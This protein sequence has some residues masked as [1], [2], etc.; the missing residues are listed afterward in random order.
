MT[1]PTP[2]LQSLRGSVLSERRLKVLL[3][4]LIAGLLLGIF[5]LGY[6]VVR[7]VFDQMLP[8][9]RD[10]LVWKTVHGAKEIAA[11]AELGI[12]A[13][14]A[15]AIRPLIQDM[16]KDADTLAVV[17]TDERGTP[18]VVAGQLPETTAVFFHGRPGALRKTDAYL[19][20]WAPAVIE[21]S[22][23]GRVAVITATRSLKAGEQLARRMILI[24]GVGSIAALLVGLGFIAFYI[25]PLV[26]LNREAFVQL[27]QTTSDA[28][29]LSEE[30]VE[31]AA[32]LEVRVRERTAE[33]SAANQ[34]LATN[35]E[36]LKEAQRKLVDISRQA[37]MAEIATGLLHN[38]GNVLN[39]VNVSASLVADRLNRS[40]ISGL[41]KAV[42][43][44]QEQ[45][46]KV[47]EFLATDPRGR[48]LPEFLGLL[49][50]H[51][52]SEVADN[53]TEMA[54]LTKHVDHIKTI[55][56]MQQAHARAGGVKEVLSLQ[57]L[58]EDA[59]KLHE[60]S[61][62]RHD[63]D[64]V[65]DLEDLPLLS[66]DRHKTLQILLNLL[67]NAKHALLHVPP[68]RRSLTIRVH[69]NGDERVHV[70]VA[71]T[72]TGIAPE[73]LTRIFSH[74]FTTKKDGHGFGLHSS[75]LAAQE[76][77]GS[78]TVHS[79]G[80]GKGATFTLSL[81]MERISEHGTTSDRHPAIKA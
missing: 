7:Q 21:G 30:K 34:A 22:A 79:D 44:L 25:G 23:V 9:L 61:L 2:T 20:A 41:K 28:V 37:G 3:V 54:S 64:L 24:A 47:S 31:L 53:R 51:L 81:P 12:A 11:S 15:S 43:L 17:V 59:L 36:K 78:L 71:D 68:G 10:D 69:A 58:V 40:K 35:L 55:V 38:V 66:I 13:H 49:S 4:S 48:K 26:R 70:A 63:V 77:G 45:G 74:G 60:G 76:M 33:L 80:L 8:S 27:E 1:G 14:D 16:L 19:S 56:S 5:G 65:R 72:G 73:N 46:D 6:V 32:S 39:S 29:K 75:A 67:S 62:S 57:G 52:A 42:E 18:L 50:E